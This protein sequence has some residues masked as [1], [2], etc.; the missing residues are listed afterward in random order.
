MASLAVRCRHPQRTGRVPRVDL[1]FLHISDEG[2][3]I[4][5]PRPRRR[6]RRGRGV[7]HAFGSGHRRVRP[8]SSRRRSS[9]ARYDSAVDAFSFIFV[10]PPRRLSC[11]AY[12]STRSF[13]VHR[14]VR[15]ETWCAAGCDGWTLRDGAACEQFL[16][17]AAVIHLSTTLRR[18]CGMRHFSAHA[19]HYRA[20]A[21]REVVLAAMPHNVAFS[22][23]VWTSWDE[24]AIAC[25]GANNGGEWGSGA[26][27]RLGFG[28]ALPA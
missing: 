12:R 9:L 21:P 2:Y 11:Y 13:R 22:R 8:T 23:S 3:P 18:I 5:R 26:G 20:L 16:S 4:T 24:D 15:P 1:A 25:L 6:D 19:R 7:Q 27:S 28:G 10:K 17:R 14:R